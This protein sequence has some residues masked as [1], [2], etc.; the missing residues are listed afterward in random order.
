MLYGR[1]GYLLGC[2][3]LNKHLGAGSL[4]ITDEA[5]QMV[6]QAVVASGARGSGGGQSTRCPAGRPCSLPCLAVL[7]CKV[8]QLPAGVPPGACQPTTCTA[9][10]LA[11]SA[12]A[13]PAAGR[14]LAGRLRG[15]AAFPT[16]LLFLWP[17]G[18]DACPYLGA[19]HGLTGEP[20]LAPPVRSAAPQPAPLLQAGAG[21]LLLAL[22]AL[23][24]CGLCGTASPTWGGR[25]AW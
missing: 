7:A 3:L 20:C 17:P 14:S 23:L 21:L 8:C 18:P 15:P 1:S 5:M 16:Q 25:T 19:A 24:R 10:C 2:L 6:T 11:S 22:A 12:G 9:T 13:P 4:R